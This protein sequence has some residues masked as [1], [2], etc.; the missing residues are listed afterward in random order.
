MLG[1][2]VH[3]LLSLWVCG[4]PTRR[5]LGA[6]GA[7]LGS[8][9]LPSV[10]LGCIGVPLGLHLGAFG[11]PLGCLWG[12]IWVSLGLSA[13]VLRKGRF[14]GCFFVPN[15]DF[16]TIPPVPRAMRA[17][18]LWSVKR[19]QETGYKK[20]GTLVVRMNTPLVPGGYGGGYEHVV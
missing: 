19:I 17:G 6:F 10:P 12:V 16:S 18:T 7:S 8:L 5:I 13:I 14:V 1:S 9:G 3:Y 20:S 15:P 2:C 4:A 11:V